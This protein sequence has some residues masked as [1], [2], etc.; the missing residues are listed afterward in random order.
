M[1]GL[2]MHLQPGAQPACGKH[3]SSNSRTFLDTMQTTTEGC[4][5]RD[6]LHGLLHGLLCVMACIEPLYVLE[7]GWQHDTRAGWLERQRQM[8]KRR[9]T[10]K[11][12][13]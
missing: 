9:L 4:R 5:V 2:P 1:L 6:I 7:A 8:R 12:M 13:Q 3:K 11:R 10:S